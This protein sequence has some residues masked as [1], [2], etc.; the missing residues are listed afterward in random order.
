MTAFAAQG[1]LLRFLQLV[2]V[3]SPCH[4][5]CFYHL[6]LSLVLS[7]SCQDLS[8]VKRSHPSRGES[9]RTGNN[10]LCWFTSLLRT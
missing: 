5:L 3:P 10:S 8:C 4:R 9:R 7:I 2:A 6:S 1:T